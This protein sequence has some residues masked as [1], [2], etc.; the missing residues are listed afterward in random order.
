[1]RNLVEQ[2]SLWLQSEICRKGSI[3]ER[4]A[5]VISAFRSYVVDQKDEISNN[6]GLSIN[7]IIGKIDKTSKE[8]D[9]ILS[10]FLRGNHLDAIQMTRSMMKNMKFEKFPPSITFYKSRENGRLFHYTKDEMFHIPYNKRNLVGN[11]RFS[12]SG[13][14]CLYLGGS[15]YI[16][17]EELGRKDLNTSNYCGY[18]LT[19]EVNMFDM[20]LPITITNSQQIR[21]IILTLACSLS[22]SRD[23]VFKPEYIIPQCILHSLIFRSFYNHSPFCVRYY[24]SHMLNG[25]ADFFKFSYSNEDELNRYINYVFPATSSKEDGYSDELKALF[26][27]SETITLMHETILEPD[28]IICGFSDDVY[29]SSQFGLIDAIIDEKMGV[30]PKRVEGDILLLRKSDTKSKIK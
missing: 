18:I 11:Q 24:S 12:L 17:W 8:I 21:K 27:Q 10:A 9:K 30:I 6:T 15:S 26:N 19:K 3:R 14:P 7:I 25:D 5:A 4:T 28:R 1:M 13:L 2:A 20:L 16:C 23:D 29:L 22:A